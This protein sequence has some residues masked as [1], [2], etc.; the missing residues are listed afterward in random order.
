MLQFIKLIS[1]QV[2]NIINNNNN[3]NNHINN[4]NNNLL[5]LEENSQYSYLNDNNY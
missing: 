4:N 2:K 1:D 5:S 3:N